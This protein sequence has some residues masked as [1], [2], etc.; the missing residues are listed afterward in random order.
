LLGFLCGLRAG[1]QTA[2][3]K[4][5]SQGELEKTI[6]TLETAL[7]DAYNHCDLE[8]FAAL[9]ADDVEFYHDQRGL[10]VGKEL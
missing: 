2:L 5:T 1:A 4:I 3:E 6:A 8:K 10:T 7:F 9:L